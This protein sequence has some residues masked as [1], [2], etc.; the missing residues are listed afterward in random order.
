MNWFHVGPS[1][2]AAFLGSL[3]EC[4]EAAT[5]VLAVGTVR[6]W[7]S[8]LLGTAVWLASLVAL[9]VELGWALKAVPIVLLQ[10]VIGTMLLL[11]GLNWLRK[12]VLRAAGLMP[13]HNEATAFMTTTA[14]LAKTSAATSRRWDAVALVTT[15]K[16]VI[17]E[18]I[19]VVFIV[20][21]VRAA[22]QLLLPASI[23]AIIAGVTVA[24]AALILRRPL[25]RIPENALK[26]SVGVLLASFGAFWI[27]EGAGLQW[28]GADLSILGL[29]AGVLV[30]SLA[31]VAALRPQNALARATVE[32]Y[33]RTMK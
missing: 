9:V 25:A 5:I 18:G 20:L 21:S 26:F 10:L 1:L 29:A 27:G 2:T 30:L 13:R 11:F 31:S 3:V 8:A 16:A 24:V 15:C 28:P 6:G 23:G 19:E 14:A 33:E 7:S 12:A 17:L 22:G 4:V 32:S